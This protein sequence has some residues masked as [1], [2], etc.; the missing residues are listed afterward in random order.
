MQL[1]NDFEIQE[2]ECKGD[3]F[4]VLTLITDTGA[5]PFFFNPEVFKDLAQKSFLV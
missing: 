1:V 2:I 4:V 3:S 5:Y